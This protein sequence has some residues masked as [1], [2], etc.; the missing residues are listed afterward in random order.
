MM[1]GGRAL[2]LILGT[3]L[4]AL[5]G[6]SGTM[7]VAKS[8]RAVHRECS[9]DERLNK[10]CAKPHKTEPC[11]IFIYKDMTVSVSSTQLGEMRT[12]LPDRAYAAEGYRGG[13][14]KT[15]GLDFSSLVH[16]ETD[17]FE[18]NNGEIAGLLSVTVQQYHDP[19]GKN[20]TEIICK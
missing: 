3:G 4:F 12:S 2:A 20:W 6:L 11:Q 13:L 10:H 8:S 16:G 17:V 5:V 1:L 9:L 15:F 14:V 7:A 19:A 18:N